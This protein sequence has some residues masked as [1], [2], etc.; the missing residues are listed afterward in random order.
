MLQEILRFLL[1]GMPG[2]VAMTISVIAY[3]DSLDNEQADG[4]GDSQGRRQPALIICTAPPVGTPY[5]RG[6]GLCWFFH[7][8][9]PRAVS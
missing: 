1:Y 3:M 6:P 7:Y 5:A 8:S 4:S 9:M 2:W